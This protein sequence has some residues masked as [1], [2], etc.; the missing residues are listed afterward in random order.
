M[1]SM[2]LPYPEM[3][4]LLVNFTSQPKKGKALTKL[5]EIKNNKEWFSFV[6]LKENNELFGK[7][8]EKN[9]GLERVVKD[10]K[11]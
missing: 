5:K 7:T 8:L 11:P 3:K 6:C 4:A 1:S 9:L 2:R 10:N